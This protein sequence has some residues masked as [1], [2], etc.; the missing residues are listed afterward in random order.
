MLGRRTVNRLCGRFFRRCCAQ[1]NEIRNG[2]KAICQSTYILHHI[3]QELDFAHIL[4]FLHQ[5]QAGTFGIPKLVRILCI[6]FCSSGCSPG[7]SL[8]SRAS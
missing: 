2:L 6:V 3:R 5:R 8:R 1:L 4:S 7:M